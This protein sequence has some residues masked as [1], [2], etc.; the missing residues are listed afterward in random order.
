[1]SKKN[2]EAAAQITKE[3]V[4][5]QLRAPFTPEDETLR[6]HMAEYLAAQAEVFPIQTKIAKLEEQAEPLEKK[7][8][9][10]LAEIAKGT[11]SEVEC[12][13][14]INWLTGKVIVTRNDTE[15]IVEEREVNE[16]D[17]QTRAEL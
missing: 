12:T 3:A 2:S 9:T 15:E 14:E 1:M 17:K 10:A 4:V 6:A 13:Q 11:A 7:M 8:K 16:D 5:R